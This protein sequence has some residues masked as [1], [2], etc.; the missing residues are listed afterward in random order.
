[1][2]KTTKKTVKPKIKVSKVPKI[3]SAAC[4]FRAAFNA[5]WA[6]A[7]NGRKVTKKIYSHT[8]YWTGI[9]KYYNQTTYVLY[10]KKDVAWE[11]FRTKVL[12]PQSKR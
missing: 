4:V 9:R 1:M 12:I 5:G 10:K 3:Q 8:D 2:A 6:A 7:K 11:D